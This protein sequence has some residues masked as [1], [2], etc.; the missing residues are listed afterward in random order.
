MT[1]AL[2]A[3][4]LSLPPAPCRVPAHPVTPTPSLEELYQSGQTFRSFLE[5]A[6]ARRALWL[7]NWERAEVPAGLLERARALNRSWRLLAIAVDG[8]SDSVSTIP[9]I[10]MLVAQVEGLDM[11]IADPEAG[12]PIMEAHRTPDG[13]AAT[14]TLILIDGSWQ[15]SGCWVERPAT[16]QKWYLENPEG[17]SRRD[18]VARKM[19]WYYEDAGAST[20][21]EIVAIIEA[22]ERGERICG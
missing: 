8:C 17:L 18:L 11:R 4:L 2:L 6:D 22:A 3:L 7:D 12:R 16:L 14:P 1:A 13:R 20:L 21:A 15:E 19:E 9:F 10:A 5:A